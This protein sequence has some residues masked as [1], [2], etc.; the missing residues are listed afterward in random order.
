MT[1]RRRDRWTYNSDSSQYGEA[2]WHLDGTP[3]VLDFMPGHGWD[4]KGEYQLYNDPCLINHTSVDRY[5]D[6]AMRWTEEHWD[7]T[8]AGASASRTDSTSLMAAR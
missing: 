3:L 7:T 8:H 6:G 1:T 5:M 4:G 2:G